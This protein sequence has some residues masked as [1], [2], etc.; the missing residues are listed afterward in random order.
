LSISCKDAENNSEQ[1]VRCKLIDLSPNILCGLGHWFSD[2]SIITC[3][4]GLKELY[5]EI[6]FLYSSNR[7]FMN[8]RCLVILSFKDESFDKYALN[9]LNKGNPFKKKVSWSCK[10]IDIR[11]SSNDKRKVIYLYFIVI[12]IVFYFI[13]NNICSVVTFS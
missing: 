1:L 4:T 7:K 8:L 11:Y 12:D 6:L 10:N 2:P 9:I 5:Y 13:V 3:I